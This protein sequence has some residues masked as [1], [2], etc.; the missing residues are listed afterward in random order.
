M[1]DA[2]PEVGKAGSFP[3]WAVNYGDDFAALIDALNGDEFRQ[4]VEEKFSVDLKDRPTMFTVRGKCRSKDGKIHTDT[5][6]K[7]ITVLLYMNRDWPH[8]GGRLRIL[9][10]GNDI[11]DEAAEV[12]PLAGTMVIFKRSDHSFHA[13]LP[14]DGDRKVIQMNWVTHQ[15]FVDREAK[16][17]GWSA[18]LKRLRPG[19]SA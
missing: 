10:S 9:R 1:L 17:H 5:A 3:L 14:Y 8:P 11:N 19:R 4:I 6:S 15:D 18:F 2:Y 12:A 7:I 13:H 16:R